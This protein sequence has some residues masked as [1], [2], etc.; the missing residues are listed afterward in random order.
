MNWKPQIISKAV[1][2]TNVWDFDPA[3]ILNSPRKVRGKFHTPMLDRDIEFIESQ[4]VRNAVPEFMH[5]PILHDFHKERTVGIVTRVVELSDGTFDFE[6]LIKATDDCNDIWEL[7]TK[8]KYDQV[9]I[10]GK[11]TCGSGACNVRPER[12]ME[13]C[14]TTAVRI[15]SIS[16]CD[17]N[18]RNVGTS[19][20]VRKGG[21]VVFTANDAIIKAETTD[22]SLMHEVTDRPKRVFGSDGLPRVPKK[23][24]ATCPQ[25]ERPD[26][27]KGVDMD[28]D[29]NR[30]PLKKQPSPK[31]VNNTGTRQAEEGYQPVKSTDE[32]VD[33]LVELS[34]EN[35]F[36]HET[37]AQ[38]IQDEGRRK[39]YIESSKKY[40][41]SDDEEPGMEE[42]IEEGNDLDEGIE[43]KLQKLEHM[44]EALL[45]KD[46]Q[47]LGEPSPDVEDKADYDLP[48]EKERDYGAPEPEAGREQE[49]DVN[50]QPKAGDEEIDHMAAKIHLSKRVGEEKAALVSEEKAI[51]FDKFA[52][53]ERKVPRISDKTSP[54]EVDHWKQMYEAGKAP[55]AERNAAG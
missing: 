8:G 15:D 12:R 47:D 51:P 2:P 53:G 18:A 20:E 24:T 10:Y 7:I 9:S 13:P 44:V 52:S 26:V 54:D 49:M 1:K 17:D 27:E 45:N 48:P 39:R 14:V 46:K 28:E 23:C 40:A 4:A 32:E 16:V 33:R 50:P 22:S 21:K 5:L 36:D 29:V 41:K 3:E 38:G 30:I 19:L 43:A 35:N 37:V 31:P 25:Y 6:G 55:Y 34:E 42:P 11:R